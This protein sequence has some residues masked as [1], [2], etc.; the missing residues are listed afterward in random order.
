MIGWITLAFLNALRECDCQKDAPELASLVLDVFKHRKPIFHVK[1]HGALKG[2]LALNNTSENR[3][4]GAT[5]PLPTDSTIKLLRAILIMI[6]S[7]SRHI[8]HYTLDFLRRV[9][10]CSKTKTNITSTA[11]ELSRVFGP[12]F[13]GT[14][15][16]MQSVSATPSSRIGSVAWAETFCELLIYAHG[17]TTNDTTPASGA[18]A[19]KSN[20]KILV[21]RKPSVLWKVPSKLQDSINECVNLQKT[22]SRRSVMSANVTPSRRPMG[23]SVSRVIGQAG[24]PVSGS[25]SR[26]VLFGSPK[27]PTQV[28]KSP[29]K[30]L[31]TGSM[32]TQ[33]S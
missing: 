5:T 7:E 33:F 29:A 12:I 11:R 4:P 19:A 22:P 3:L 13:V 21:R 16:S 23:T 28:P 2:I 30:F 1:F 9:C 14:D 10:D 31:F 25:S 17:L 26:R 18:S 27:A 20:R 15:S 8:L 24:M 6:E 32:A